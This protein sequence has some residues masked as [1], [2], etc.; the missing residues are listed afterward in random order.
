MLHNLF[1]FN[2]IFVRIRHSATKG[3]AAFPA[4]L[5]TGTPAWGI[6]NDHNHNMAAMFTGL[7]RPSYTKNNLS[8]SKLLIVDTASNVI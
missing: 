7:G 5:E 1:S 6:A 2:P 4:S 3:C 8:G